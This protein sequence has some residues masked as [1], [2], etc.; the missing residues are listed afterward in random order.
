MERVATGLR[1]GP[2]FPFE[3]LPVNGPL[4]IEDVGAG[5]E[6]Q[7]TFLLLTES[8]RFE[9]SVERT[10]TTCCTPLP[11]ADRAPI[12]T[13]AKLVDARLRKDWKAIRVL[14]PQDGSIEL[15]WTGNCPIG[16]DDD[17][18]C[19]ESSRHAQITRRSIPPRARRILP[20]LGM[21]D[22]SDFRCSNTEDGASQCCANI[23]M[24]DICIGLRSSHDGLVI[25][26]ISTNDWTH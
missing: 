8:R 14:A 3:P 15:L 4:L 11:C 5:A 12:S 22:I 9:L 18:K 25:T 16:V 21:A 10:L 23:P 7:R 6:C 24:D 2:H 1:S 13:V 26:S 20:P 19:P 17:R